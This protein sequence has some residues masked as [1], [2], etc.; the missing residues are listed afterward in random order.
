MKTLGLKN[1]ITEIKNSTD[2]L[3]S[4]L[5]ITNKRIRDPERQISRKYIDWNERQTKKKKH[6][7]YMKRIWDTRNGITH[8]FLETRKEKIDIILRS[9]F[10]EPISKNGNSQTQKVT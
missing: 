7:K 10:K 8:I 3:N 4:R 9:S 1:T 5:D 2:S 6:R